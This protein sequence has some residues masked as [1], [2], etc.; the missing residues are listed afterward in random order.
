VRSLPHAAGVAVED[1]PGVEDGLDHPHQRMV[2]DPVAEGC[3]A[4]P[5]PFGTLDEEKV[6]KGLARDGAG[7]G[8]ASAIR[9]QK[10]RNQ[11]STALESQEP[12]HPK[13]AAVEEAAWAAV[14]ASGAAR[15][16]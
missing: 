8:A 7:G 6:F 9:N 1:E 10:F 3:G 2:D 15:V 13:P 16:A 5:A 14:G 12:H 4:D 11:K